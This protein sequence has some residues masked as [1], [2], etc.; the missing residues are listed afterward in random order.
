MRKEYETADRSE[1]GESGDRYK[2]TEVKGWI[3]L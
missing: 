3:G 1:M 2:E